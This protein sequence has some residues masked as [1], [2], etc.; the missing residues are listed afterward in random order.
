MFWF[1]INPYR[2][3]VYRNIIHHRLVY[4][5]LLLLF[6]GGCLSFMIGWPAY[7]FLCISFVLI[8]VYLLLRKRIKTLDINKEYTDLELFFFEKKSRWKIVVLF[9]FSFGGNIISFLMTLFSIEH[10]K[11]SITSI[12]VMALFQ[13][14]FIGIPYVLLSFLSRKNS[15]WYSLWSPILLFAFIHFF[16]FTYMIGNKGNLITWYI[17]P[18]YEVLNGTFIPGIFSVIPLL[19]FLDSLGKSFGFSLKD[20]TWSFGYLKKKHKYSIIKNVKLS[21]I[22]FACSFIWCIISSYYCYNYLEKSYESRFE[23]FDRSHYSASRIKFYMWP[24]INKKMDDYI[25]SHI[26]RNNND[27]R[28][29]KND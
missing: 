24:E 4:S 12:F 25:D 10:D 28:M 2:W 26:I 20:E 6:V 16:F 5:I 13:F 21:I 8:I 17:Q 29:K 19:L 14:I 15:F 3:L 7:V 11:S 1:N 22:G 23:V 18:E 9:F 27:N